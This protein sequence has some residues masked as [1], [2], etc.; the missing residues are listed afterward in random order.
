M[1]AKKFIRKHRQKFIIG[2]G[3]V[4]V[5]FLLSGVLSLSPVPATLFFTSSGDETLT[6]GDTTTIDVNIDAQVPV[7]A[8]GTIVTY[9]ED[10]FEVINI[11]KK[12][13]FIDL[14]TH[15]AH[16]H[17]DTGSEVHF[18]GGTLTPGGLM[19]TGTLMALNVRAKRAGTAEFNFKDAQIIASD[20][21]GTI[22]EHAT[23]PL[24]YTIV[25]KVV[26]VGGGSPIIQ[27]SRDFNG[28]GRAT[29]ADVS[30]LL[31]QMFSTYDTLYDLDTDGSVGF[32]D[33]SII[34]SNM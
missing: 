5:V 16:V 7:N 27:V 14:W 26:V 24:T 29:L 20:G 4:I 3:I 30:I 6:V 19:G 13:T 10:M 15:E 11:D 23:H 8:L 28:D 33:F 12:K 9:P 31:V 32:S 18:S 21:L 1:A 2:H 17:S 25:E 22:V 34:L